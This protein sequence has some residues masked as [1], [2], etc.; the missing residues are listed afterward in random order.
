MYL[1]NTI[2]K[3]LKAILAIIGIVAL[4]LV[5]G[6]LIPFIKV[7]AEATSD[8]KTVDIYIY[9]NGVHTDLVV[10]VKNQIMDWSKEISFENTVSKKTGFN[11]VGIGWGD[12]GFYMDTPTWADLKF[13]T[14]FKA[15]FWLSESA[16][17]CTFY[18]KMIEGKDCK[19]ISLTENQYRKLVSF[20]REKFD[21]NASGET[22]LIKTDAVYDVNDAFYEAKGRYSFLDTCNTWVNEGLKKAGQKAALWTPTDFGIFQHYD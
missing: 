18:E 13:S 8:P 1:K 2:I 4:Y 11:Y 5:V 14:A 22:I 15:A 12:K 20:I 9:T 21:R 6:Y 3:I 16:M 19:K 7:D 17:H 10:P